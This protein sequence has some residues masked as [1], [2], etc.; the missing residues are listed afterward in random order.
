MRAAIVLVAIL[1]LAAF[2]FEAP[3]RAQTYA[4]YECTDGANFEAAFYP[5][6][7]FAFLQIDGKSLK[8]P[9]RLWPTG[10]RF[11]KSGVVLSLKSSGNATIKRSGRT[12][13]CKVK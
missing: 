5:E 4:H 13:Q 1:T 9:K 11:S 10:Q 6:T 3:A 2:G 7:K 12:S 8:L